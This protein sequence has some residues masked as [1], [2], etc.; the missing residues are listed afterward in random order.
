MEPLRI[1]ERQAQ[2]VQLIGRGLTDRQIAAELGLSIR[3]VN[4]ALA[5]LYRR[6][7]V[8]GRDQAFRVMLA[9]YSADAR[10]L[11]IPPG[12]GFGPDD[13]A[14][15]Q[16][17]VSGDGGH[18]SL[19]DRWRKPPRGVF[20]RMNLVLVGAVIWLLILSG[21]SPLFVVTMDRLQTW[22]LEWRMN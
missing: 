20:R 17:L 1:T 7:G 16:P 10:P 5:R 15:A 14:D 4:N 8:A 2:L 22:W 11:L 19:I 6:L 12:Y 13:I 21:A 18:E 9:G 3:A